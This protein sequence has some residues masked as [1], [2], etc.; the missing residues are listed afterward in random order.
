MSTNEAIGIVS[1]HQH[2]VPLKKNVN[3]TGTISKPIFFLI[4]LDFCSCPYHISTFV[5][6][7][8]N[9]VSPRKGTSPRRYPQTTPPF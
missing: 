2:L 6:Y 1:Q 8:F 9:F 7:L 5:A 4:N 3:K